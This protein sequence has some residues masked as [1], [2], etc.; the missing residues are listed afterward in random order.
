MEN[1][2]EFRNRVSKDV[3]LQTSFSEQFTAWMQLTI[4]MKNYFLKYDWSVIL[5]KPTN[6]QFFPLKIAAVKTLVPG[7]D[8][9]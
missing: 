8:Y 4:L 5:G 6:F 9:L 7:F 1:D 3:F 2:R